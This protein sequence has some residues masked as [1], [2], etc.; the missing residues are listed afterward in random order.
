M[1][2]Q[3]ARKR[4]VRTRMAKLNVHEHAQ[5]PERYGVIQIP[6]QL[7]IKGG[8]VVEQNVGG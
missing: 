4:Q 7:L 5:H 1:T 2:D 6:T 3:K 8:Q